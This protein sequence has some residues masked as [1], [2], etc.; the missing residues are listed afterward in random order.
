MASSASIKHPKIIIVDGHTLNPG[1]LSWESLEKLGKVSVYEH[2][3]R[4]EILER[5]QEAEI[6]LAN[7]TV[8]DAE[9]LAQLPHLRCICVTATGF[10]NIDIISAK[11]HD[12]LVCNVA[13]YGTDAVA[14]HVFALLLELTNAVGKHHGSVQNGDWSRNRDFC[15]TLQPV[16]ELAGKTMGIYGFGKIGQQVAKIA[17][18]FGM[19]ILA[20]HKHPKRDAMPGVR[21]VDLE[22]LFQKSDIIT[23]HAP[24]T[25]ENE[26]F[27]NKTLLSKM[28]PSAYLINTARGGL[29]HESDLKE[30]LENNI[31]A[32]AGLDVLSQ[33]PPKNG[34]ILLN[35]KNCIITPHN[36]WA[37][38]EA[39]QRL[40]NETVEN[41]KAFLNGKPRNVV[42]Y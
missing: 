10:N 1:D 25:T 14:Q 18:A 11:K 13:G 20:T 7:K 31:I 12:I 22:T 29:I 42:N 5:T 28:K 37:S 34:N 33:E 35:V 24:L 30:A 6:I 8:F 26:Y 9:I 23:L 19:E 27:V 2:S 40:L 36:A 39:R 4:E 3:T 41:V 17:L 16:I 32:G 21:F 38:R 15:Y